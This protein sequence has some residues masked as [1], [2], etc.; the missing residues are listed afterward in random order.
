MSVEVGALVFFCCPEKSWTVGTVT[1]WDAKKKMGSCKAKEGGAVVSKLKEESIFV[2]REDILDED[3]NDLLHLTLLHDSTLLNVLRMRYMRDT[4]YTNIG[5]IVVA[6]NPFNFKIPHYVDAK[7]PDYLAEGDRIERNLPHSWA[8]AHNTYYEMMNDQYNQCILVSGES[9]AGKTEASKIVMKYL[10]AVSCKSGNDT[11][12]S[13]AMQVGTKIN[14]CSPPLES[15]GNAKTVRNDNSSRFGKFMKVRFSPDGILTGA[16]I[17]KYLLEKSRIITA[18]PNERIYHSF[19]LLTR[20][21]DAGKYNVKEPGCYETTCNAGKC[22]DI[23][24]VDDGEDYSICVEAMKNCGFNADQIDGTWR[25]C[26]GALQLGTVLF[27]EIDKDTCDFIDKSGIADACASW[28]T[29]PA[30]LEHELMTTTMTTRDGP[31][32][33]KLNKAAATDSRD[34]LVRTTYDNTFSWQVL[35][36]NALTDSGTGVNF[37]GLLDIFGF[38]DFEYNSFEQLCINLANETLQNHYNTYIFTKDMDECRA[39]GVD[40]TEVKCPDNMPCLKMMTDKTGIFGLLDDECSVGTGSDA[41]FLAKVLD[42]HSKN[43]FFGQKKLAK[44]SFIVHHYA[45]SVNYTVEQWLEKNRDTLKPAVKLLMRQSGHPLIAELLPAPD[46]NAKKVTVGGYFK[47]QLGQLMAL[48]NSTSP[49]WIRCVKPHPAKKPLMVDGITMMTQLESSGVLGTVKIRKAGFPVRPSFKKFVARFKVC[50]QGPY[51]SMDSDVAVLSD[52]CGKII[53]AVGMDRMKA[54]IGKTRVFMKNE[55]NQEMEACRERALQEHV[56]N[57]KRFSLARIA[58]SRVRYRRWV[59]AAIEVQRELRGWFERT[60][61]IRAEMRRWRQE[62]ARKM[63]I[64]YRGLA[65]EEISGR[66]R[67]E[68]EW[69]GVVAEMRSELRE[70]LRFWEAKLEKDDEERQKLYAECREERLVMFQEQLPFYAHA[71]ARMVSV[72]LEACCILEHQKRKRLAPD[73]AR[74]WAAL[75][76]LADADLVGARL[77]SM[78]RT[79]RGKRT[80]LVQLDRLQRQELHERR[81]F[82]PEYGAELER[83]AGPWVEP[84]GAVK[85]W[86]SFI[87]KRRQRL[88]DRRGLNQE[89]QRFDEQAS[90]AVQRPVHR[91]PAAVKQTATKPAWRGCSGVPDADQLRPAGDRPPAPRPLPPQV[92]PV[93]LDGSSGHP[94]RDA[95]PS[96]SRSRSA[97][98]AGSAS[99]AARRSTSRNRKQLLARSPVVPD[100]SAAQLRS[101]QQ[102]GALLGDLGKLSQAQFLHLRQQTVSCFLD[103]CAVGRYPHGGRWSDEDSILTE[104]DL[105]KAQDCLHDLRAAFCDELRRQLVLYR[106]V[107]R[108]YTVL[109]QSRVTGQW[110]FLTPAEWSLAH[111]M[112][113]PDWKELKQEKDR[114]EY[115]IQ[116]HKNAMAQL[117]TAAARH[118]VTTLVDPHEGTPYSDVRKGYDHLVRSVAS[119]LRG[120]EDVVFSLLLKRFL[121]AEER[122]QPVSPRSPRGGK[123][124]RTPRAHI[125][126]VSPQRRGLR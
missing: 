13:A 126:A 48:I 83:V 49:H 112:D 90:R 53:G 60:A 75:L 113:T 15:Y 24:K 10:A 68:S 123:R 121:P 116:N 51:P 33:K 40:V 62:Q 8:V 59:A 54:Q 63:Q 93:P 107:C 122:V 86:A 102:R 103:L 42:Q 50:A 110:H 5:A 88:E 18:N 65:D 45:A 7:M 95:S 87:R 36:I 109:E 39:E 98:R 22:V 3:V 44:N 108:K 4:I 69:R 71:R 115:A 55:A 97:P 27:K 57:L 89:L 79:E 74:A 41:G 73:E 6:L 101:A 81:L 64:A 37:I 94:C 70:A 35:A 38:E 78:H 82:L 43:P 105:R 14:A 99:P 96:R 11:Q 19:Y 117:L 120:T 58:Q 21:C 46:E 111:F 2:A 20:G 31:V 76:A 125:A 30:V 26:A 28:M 106:N 100:H 61:E 85:Y 119:Q 32:V 52:F 118:G 124:A 67:I 17:T 72:L 66:E 1:E 23:P 114:L 77:R 104:R 56:R 16:H 47:D 12:K 92:P 25:M 34:S 84:L 9:G 29:D 80:V 91:E